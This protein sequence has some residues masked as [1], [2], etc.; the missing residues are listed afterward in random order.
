[1]ASRGER[2][3]NARVLV[4]DDE[5]ESRAVLSALLSSAGAKVTSVEDAAGALE[6]LERT[7]FDLLVIDLRL[8]DA[9]GYELLASL[10]EGAKDKETPPAIAVTGF[11][12]KA[13]RSSAAKAGFEAYVLK[14]IDADPFLRTVE[15][16]LRP[17]QA[18]A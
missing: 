6:Q 12:S 1:V 14:P 8:P 17:G 4:V 2:L 9:L 5:R 16:V 15:S 10:R 3:R 13:Y 11:D 7:H 18:P